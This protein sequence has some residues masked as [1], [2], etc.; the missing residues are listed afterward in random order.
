MIINGRKLYDARPVS[1]MA[2]MKL[3]EHGVSYGLAEA[4]YDL[5][6]KQSVT[7]HPF[8]RFALASTIERFDMPENLVAIVHDKSSNI[9]RGLMVGNSVV[10]PGW[11]GWLTLELFYFGW[12][13]L[14]IEAGT[15][16]AQAIF[17][18]LAEAATYGNGKYQDQPDHPV[19]AR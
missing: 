4:G 14:R 5:R 2:G 10:E 9:R 13:P 3:R 18:E 8:R 1:P 17:H 12:K 15:G 19:E 6:I 16:I 11:R 7:L